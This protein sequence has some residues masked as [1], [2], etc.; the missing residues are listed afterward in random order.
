LIAVLYRKPDNDFMEVQKAALK[1]VSGSVVVPVPFMLNLTGFKGV[2][3]I[4]L[5][6]VKF[7]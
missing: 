3:L 7:K 1:F 6:I 2:K 4:R 5:K